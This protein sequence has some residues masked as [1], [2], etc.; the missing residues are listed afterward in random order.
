MLPGHFVLVGDQGA[1]YTSV[2]SNSN[3]FYATAILQNIKTTCGEP[4]GL[5]Y[6]ANQY[7][8]VANE[9]NGNGV[10]IAQSNDAKTWDEFIINAANPQ[11]SSI[12]AMTDNKFILSGNSMVMSGTDLHNL[13]TNN[14]IAGKSIKKLLQ[15]K[16]TIIALC[17]D[18][19]IYYASSNDLNSWTQ[20][21]NFSQQVSGKIDD[22]SI[23]N[24]YI[25]AVGAN[26]KIVY[27]NKNSYPTTI[28]W[29]NLNSS[30][31]SNQEIKFIAYGNGKYVGVTSSSMLSS[32]GPTSFTIDEQTLS[33][34]LVNNLQLNPLNSLTFGAGY[35]MLTAQ[36]S[37]LDAGVN[38]SA[39]SVDGISWNNG[40]IISSLPLVGI[41]LI[42]VATF[43]L[44]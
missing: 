26:A 16:Q 34:N 10:C 8:V 15:V 29:I 22:I 38:T 31:S 17:S 37:G 14:F 3:T 25:V 24:D 44:N 41:P 18:N 1:I 23:G 12:L 28:N 7:V 42:R 20:D 6:G 40:T 5:T 11:I 43:G 13:E 2:N 36:S 30:L 21:I 4:T 9:K 35:F 27:T 33:I 19:S 39:N 32:R